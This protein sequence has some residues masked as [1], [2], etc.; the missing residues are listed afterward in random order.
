MLTH[1]EPDT[2]VAIIGAGFAGIGTAIRLLDAGIDDFVVLE[3]AAE[4]GGTWRDN[5]YPGCA[6]DIPSHL[7]SLSFA[8]RAD[9][10]RK[11]PPQPEIWDYLLELV[12]RHGLRRHLWTDAE[13]VSCRFDEAAARWRLA[14]ADG[15]RLA[16][17]VVVSGIGALRDPKYPSLPGMDDFAG[18][19]V[20]TAR[21]D[22]GLDLAGKRVGVVGTGASAIQVIPAVA[23]VAAHV[24]VFQRTPAWVTPRMD[25]AYEPREQWAFA[26]LP[27]RRL[28]HRAAIFARHE[29][30]WVGF[31]HPPLLRALEGLVRAHLRDQ[32]ADPELARRLEPHYRMGCK[33][34]LVSDDYYPAMNRDHVELVTAGLQRV[35]PAGLATDDGERHD[36]DVIVW[37]TGF[38]VQDVLGSL[39][40]VGLDGAHL[41]A[42]WGDHPVAH[43][44][45]TV[46]GFP[47]FFLLLGPNTGL[48]HNSVVLMI[49]SQLNYVMAA[50]ERLARHEHVAWVDARPEAL[51]AWRAEVDARSARSIWATGCDSW[52]LGDD[53]H[54]FTLWPGS[55]LEY[56]HRTRHF[57][58]RSYRLARWS[59]L[60]APA[61]TPA[62]G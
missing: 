51:A 42:A 8:P 55:V 9:W 3:R 2:M 62:P 56:R 50:I 30:R 46:P 13:V 31:T 5:V 61:T 34:I 60:P 11:Y 4:I 32:V 10:S 27:G 29:A 26:H 41:D 37:A 52:Y 24:T 18:R 36:L 22:P 38:D 6:S 44:G 58:T 1:D 49:E 53:G 12:D 28:L 57:D 47:N 40:V 17:R 20:H 14:T 15:R 33:R 21:W 54:N 23:E 59:D 19:Q 45:I 43:K 39:D 35:T 48:G 16:A 25:R 7:Y